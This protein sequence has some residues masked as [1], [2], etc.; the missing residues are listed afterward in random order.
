[1]STRITTAQLVDWLGRW[2][3]A[4]TDQKDHLTDL[5]RAIGDADHG[6][7][8]ARGTAAVTEKLEATPPQD[9]AGL[10][11]VAGMA[12]VMSVGGASGPLFGTFFLRFGTAG[13]DATE[14]DAPGLGDALHAALDGVIERG[15][16][17][18]GDKTML[19][20]IIPALEAYD[21]A[22]A[23]DADISAALAAAAAA[24]ATGR[25]AT[26]PMI[27]HKGRASYLGERSAGHMDPGAASATLLFEALAAA[28][29]G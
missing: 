2:R 16:A 15:K 8:L 17:H 23:D 28:A 12:L 24:T 26:V 9:V 29:Q 5:D 20:A 11:K 10:G 7:N 13:G 18:A 6:F 22:V 19:D 14:L 3:D 4:V 27:A 25:D 21:Q 1:M